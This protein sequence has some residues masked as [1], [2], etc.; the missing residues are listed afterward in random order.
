MPQFRAPA[1][2]FTAFALGL[3]P[4]LSALAEDYPL[5][6]GD[7]LEIAVAGYADIRETMPVNIDGE[8]VAPLAGTIRAEGRTLA[9]ITAEIRERVAMTALPAFDEHGM[10]TAEHIHPS[11]VSVTLRSYRPVYVDGAVR[12]P[13]AHDFVPGLTAR[14]A[15]AVAGGASPVEDSEDPALR[16][17]ELRSRIGDLKLRARV[18]QAR[19]DRLRAEI[20][21][22]PLAE[23]E[24]ASVEA[25]PGAESLEW[26]RGALRRARVE[27][28][29][30]YFDA[31]RGSAGTERAAL[32][33]QLAA[34]T[35]GSEADAREYDR[36]AE[37]E[38]AGTITSLRLAEARRGLLFARSS[39]WET[40]ARLA[41]VERDDRMLANLRDQRRLEAREQAAEALGAEIVTLNTLRSELAAADKA[42]GYL[43]DYASERPG[44]PPPIV[45]ISR[46]GQPVIAVPPSEDAPLRPGDL[47]HVALGEAPAAR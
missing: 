22:A 1:T 20:E 45:E 30:S 9:E 7:V 3:L 41:S 4:S 23:P 36:L 15:I 47:V 19:I 43:A 33:R 17:I 34:E 8:I 26:L 38:K 35:K 6:P 11:L 29:L 5:Q 2:L 16:M 28:D 12:R 44:A 13:G 39:Q 25:G 24:P 27:A 46:P 31:A 40:Q 32:R 14:Q 42:L 18:S 37:A 10:S 21:G